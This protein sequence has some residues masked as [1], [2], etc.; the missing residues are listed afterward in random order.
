M[1]L[2]R[3]ECELFVLCAF[4][5]P[6]IIC[7]C[8][9][10]RKLRRLFQSRRWW[11][12]W[13]APQISASLFGDTTAM[14]AEEWVTH[15]LPSN[16]LT[17]SVNHQDVTNCAVL[18]QMR[19]SSPEPFNVFVMLIVLKYLSFDTDCLSELLQEQIPTE[20]Y[21]RPHGQ[22]VWSLLQW[23]EK[24]RWDSS[25]LI[26]L[27]VSLLSRPQLLVLLFFLQPAGAVWWALM[28]LNCQPV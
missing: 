25:I 15:R 26:N 27:T 8:L 12:A 19:C 10:E 2:D 17:T 7:V 13:T 6:E 18:S 14:A 23:A 22:S 9:S 24:E 1:S 21:E 20:I 3:H 5:R 11:C 4:S 16:T 28:W